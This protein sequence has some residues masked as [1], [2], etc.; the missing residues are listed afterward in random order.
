M[1]DFCTRKNG[2]PE[3]LTQHS[4]EESPTVSVSLLPDHFLG[5]KLAPSQA[6]M[7]SICLERS[8]PSCKKILDHLLKGV[9]FAFDLDHAELKVIVKPTEDIPS[10]EESMNVL[11]ELFEVPIGTQIMIP[12]DIGDVL[13]RTI[14]KASCYYPDKVVFSSPELYERMLTVIIAG[15]ISKLLYYMP[16][17]RVGAIASSLKEWIRLF[18]PDSSVEAFKMEKC[19]PET[20]VCTYNPVTSGMWIYKGDIGGKKIGI[21]LKL[22]KPVM[23]NHSQMGM[24]KRAVF[25]FSWTV[26]VVQVV[27]THVKQIATAIV[28]RLKEPMK[29]VK[30]E[31]HILPAISGSGNENKAT[32]LEQF[33]KSTFKSDGFQGTT[34]D[35]TFPLEKRISQVSFTYSSDKLSRDYARN[36]ASQFESPKV[37][38][39]TYQQSRRVSLKVFFEGK[40]LVLFNADNLPLTK[41][42]L[43]Q[44]KIFYL[45]ESEGAKTKHSYYV[46]CHKEYFITG[47]GVELIYFIPTPNAPKPSPINFVE[48]LV[49]PRFKDCPTILR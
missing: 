5:K 12:E 9:T 30:I 24:L 37:Q 45:L 47:E 46:S 17:S 7:F 21:L 18:L 49:N 34:S 10:V 25:P 36:I 29:V 15:G 20:K 1:F 32:V 48:C 42:A 14:P 31:K 43:S 11:I 2:I 8:Y 26:P 19:A 3:A 16:N 41:D 40:V 38:T 22:G 35:D 13:Q 44:G 27:D 6:V 23:L 33:D 28:E 39:K 4:N